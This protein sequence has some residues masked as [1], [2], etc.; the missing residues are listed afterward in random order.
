MKLILGLFEGRHNLPNEVQGYI[1]NK[2]VN[3]IDI[4]NLDKEV[5]DNLSQY[6]D[7]ESLN[8]YVTGLTSATI[9]VCK[10]CMN[11]LIPLTLKHYDRETDKYVDQ[12]FLSHHQVFILKNDYGV[13]I[14]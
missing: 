2:K 1:F 10:F 6:K 7:I 3:P 12:V 13:D 9:A 5:Y 4:K 11:Y 8:L 14:I